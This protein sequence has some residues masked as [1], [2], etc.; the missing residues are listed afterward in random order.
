MNT[1]TDNSQIHHTA[2]DDLEDMTFA[3]QNSKCNRNEHL[4]YEIEAASKYMLYLPPETE[5]GQNQ[6]G[7]QLPTQSDDP[8]RRL[9]LALKDGE[10]SSGALR[11]VLEIKHRPTFRDSHLHPA[12]KAELIELTIPEKPSSSKQKY[13]LTDKGRIALNTGQEKRSI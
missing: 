10:K 13:R 6:V 3:V 8:V 9:L 4:F 5:P 12:L 2:C 1:D 11:S 7:V